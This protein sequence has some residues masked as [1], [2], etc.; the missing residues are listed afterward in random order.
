MRVTWI[1]YHL[2]YTN[3][4]FVSIWFFFLVSYQNKLLLITAKGK[5][6]FFIYIISY[7]QSECPKYL[8]GILKFLIQHWHICSSFP[9]SPFICFQIRFFLLYFEFFFANELN[10]HRTHMHKIFL[11]FKTSNLSVF[12]PHSFYSA[13]HST[14]IDSR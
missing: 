9:L 3:A 6:L 8:K 1:R 14:T 2:Q 13:R 12:L 5:L 7:H 10:F 11:F 4:S